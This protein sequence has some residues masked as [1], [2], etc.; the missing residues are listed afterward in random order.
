VNVEVERLLDL[1]AAMPASRRATFL[2]KECPDTRVRAEVES[3]LEYATGAETFFDQAIQSV[4]S[5]VRGSRE[6]AP[7][8]AFG[9]Y[10]IVSL[11]GRGGMGSV[12]LAERVDGEVQQKVAIKLLR[13]DCHRPAWRSRFLTERQLLASLHH[14]SIIHL[15]D[16]GHTEEGRPFLVMEHVEGLPIDVY[17]IGIEMPEKLK[18]F[19]RVCDA[20]A[21]AHR[22]LVIHRDLK[23]SNILV[24]P[25]GQP[26]LLDF[27]IAKLMSDTGEATQTVERML[28]PKYASPEQAAG[29]V[30][31]T[32]TDVYSLGVI[33]YE[34]I[35][36]G[37]PRNPGKDAVE[38]P[39]RVN[40]DVPRDLDFIVQKALRPEPEE[41]Y[42]SVD[43]FAADVRAALVWRPVQAR[44]GD[45]W[46]R[47]RR[48]LRRD[49]PPVVA[50]VAVV[51][52]LSTGLYLANRQRA[53]AERRF[54]EVR[55][56][57]NKLFD[58]DTEVARLAGGSKTRQLIV[59]TAL[60][61]LQ[62]MSADVRMDPG[63]ALDVGTAYMRVGRAQGV[64]I[65]ANLGQTDRADEAEAKAEALIDS[66]L[67]AQ[68]RNRTAL[69]RAMQIAHD[70]MI[71][72]G[73]RHRNADALK[74][75]QKATARLDEFLATGK[76][77]EQSD[78]SESQQVAITLI[79]VAN[80]FL[81]ADRYD[82]AIRTCERAIEI[83]RATNWPTQA[84]SALMVV[85]MARR[86]KG[87]LDEAL[88]AVRESVRVLEPPPAERGTR[89]SLNY[90]LALVREGQ[91]LGEENGVSL[92][93]STEAAAR[94][95]EA[96][97][98]ARDFAGRD[99]ND[100]L[101]QSR[102]VYGD[103]G[104][105][106]IVRHTDPRRAIALYDDALQRLSHTEGNGG[107]PLR[108]V[109]VLAASS[110]PLLRLGRRAEARSRLDKAF[111]RLAQLKLYPSTRIELGA[112]VDGA[113]RS[114]ADYEGA[115]GN[116]QRG[117]EIYDEL[118]RG[119]FA[120]QPE[121]VKT[122]IDAVELSNIW[123]PAAQLHRRAGHA[124]RAAELDRLRFELWRSWDA[125][126][127]NN[128]FVRRK[129]ANLP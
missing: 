113:L 61:Y 112:E 27:G 119:V 93:R 70:R 28:T 108:E 92:G 94:I 9:P 37:A 106:R 127:P 97:D 68:P 88:T 16:A 71:L 117:A 1:A 46:Y 42:L 67:A 69:L 41:R 18:L 126:L 22:R 56:L 58:I 109:T 24:E 25:S 47:A 115:T 74:Y 45:R 105:A 4:A 60:E 84:G 64:N 123:R 34:L 35:T 66:A 10:R 85:A 73:D 122:L 118:L 17:A 89:R 65:S 63:M 59:D 114:L 38:R 5:S 78:R 54:A 75:A 87:D 50:A 111:A 53:I 110:D 129:L 98:V 102:V 81:I 121:P 62:R 83:A 26:K 51:A 86:A 76:L 43:E 8:D 80:R 3:L 52:S 124:D 20:V 6:P 57:A 100:F 79:N 7:G 12:Y 55:Q 31:T 116:V 19:L 96:I 125:K 104:L 44:S 107:T 120:A 99:A 29:D 11:L 128:A 95:Q 101:S 72:A 49:W 36:R 14:P 40:P 39:S 32:A 82:E 91:I 2:A 13:A 33:L 21:H 90:T 23:P 30:Q 77:T 103:N 48:F 15:I